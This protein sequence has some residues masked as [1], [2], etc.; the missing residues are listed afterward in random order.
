MSPADAGDTARGHQRQAPLASPAQL[1]D[2]TPVD[3]DIYDQLRRIARSYM[4]REAPG[5]TLDPTALVHE[6]FLR[7][8]D[9]ATANAGHFRAAAATAMRHILV[10]EARRR[11]AARR[12]GGALRVTLIDSMVATAP[13]I[14]VLALHESLAELEK[15]STRRAKVVELRF[16]GGMSAAEA[17]EHLGIAV[18]TAE[19]DW[20]VARAWLRRR[21]DGAGGA[22][23]DPSH[24]NDHG[25]SA[26]EGL[27]P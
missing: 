3:P 23:T 21:L 9:H 7:L 20:Y 2:T 4:E 12:G 8:T 1:C 22:S 19:A 11:G 14:D 10:D 26:A 16:F 27:S 17:A 13:D 25:A 18:R 5:R 6:A 15:L 24:E